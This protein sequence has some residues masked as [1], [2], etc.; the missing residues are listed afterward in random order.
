MTTKES[1]EPGGTPRG[2]GDSSNRAATATKHD[3]EAANDSVFAAGK[4]A[5]LAAMKS[6]ELKEAIASENPG[7]QVEVTPDEA[8]RLGLT[9][10][11]ALSEEDI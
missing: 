7:T 6:W 9:E 8:E 10:E 1:N 2:S 4:R 5:E 3:G 11:T